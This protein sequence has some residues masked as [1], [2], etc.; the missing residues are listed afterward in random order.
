MKISGGIK[1]DGIVVGNAYD[2][3][4]SRNP[5]VRWIMSGFNESLS[6][7]VARAA[8]KTIHEIGC[9]EGYW[10]MRWNRQGISARGSDFS[11]QVISM[12]RENAVEDGLSAD[13]FAPHSIYDIETDRDSA[14]L[15]VCCEVLEHVEH[16]EEGLR[17]LQRAVEKYVILSVPR[18]P[19]WRA[20]NM[21]R[22]KY[23]PDMGNTPGHIQHWSRS[24]F[25]QLVSKH[26]DILEVKTPLPWTM[27]LGRVKE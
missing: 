25:V 18:E 22:G 27:L 15:I 5:I 13:I 3:Y 9:G 4:G 24:D 14:D 21:L 8:P 20:L 19:V 26:F 17:A 16:P 11:S 12:A 2:K 7:L 23:L 10:V 6:E 1:E